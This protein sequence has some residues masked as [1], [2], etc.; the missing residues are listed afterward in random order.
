MPSPPY[1]GNVIRVTS[2]RSGVPSPLIGQGVKLKAL[3][4]VG[5]A[6]CLQV[7]LGKHGLQ[8][9]QLQTL[10]DYGLGRN[11]MLPITS[12]DLRCNR[13]SRLAGPALHQLLLFTSTIQVSPVPSN[14][15]TS[16]A[17]RLPQG[18][19]STCF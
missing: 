8:D 12:L 4:T 3:K 7:L 6:G 14:H 10:V 2:A 1:L 18:G 16:M 9:D 5:S 13:L 19:A 17:K 15:A 11:S